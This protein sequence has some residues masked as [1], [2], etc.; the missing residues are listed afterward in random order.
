MR[1]TNDIRETIRNSATAAAFK[2]EESVLAKRE[3]KLFV[4]AYSNLFTA[5]TRKAAAAAPKGWIGEASELG[6]N[7]DGE[8]IRLKGAEPVLVPT[9]HHW[10]KHHVLRDA[11]LVAEVRAF[12]RE[13]EELRTRRKNAGKALHGMLASVPTIKKLFEIW[14]EGEAFYKDIASAAPSLPS[15]HVG[16][17]N[18]LLNLKIAA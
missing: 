1:L 3:H 2:K 15:I 14:P 7:C 16:E 9:S 12:A 17:V 18:K 11:N 6:F 8:V 13:K 4:A 5:S 10:G